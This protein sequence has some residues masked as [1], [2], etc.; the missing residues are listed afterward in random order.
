MLD[1]GAI[2]AQ[3][4]SVPWAGDIRL[5]R[6]RVGTGIGVVDHGRDAGI[7]DYGEVYPVRVVVLSVFRL[8]RQALVGIKSPRALCQCDPLHL[9]ISNWITVVVYQM[10]GEGGIW[11]HN[12]VRSSIGYNRL[13]TNPGAGNNYKLERGWC[14]RWDAKGER[15]LSGLNWRF[16]SIPR[17][18]HIPIGIAH[19]QTG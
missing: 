18:D 19:I 4:P 16:H 12:L 5:H 3:I 8:N 13:L 15:I 1:K 7:E 9:G 14:R 6:R 10:D 17:S 2:K 11:G